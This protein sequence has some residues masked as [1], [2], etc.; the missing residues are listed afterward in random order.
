[1]RNNSN[2]DFI[3]MTDFFSIL[4]SYKKTIIISVIS[5]ALF[6]VLYSLSLPN[7]YTSTVSLEVKLGQDSNKS[8]GGF[9]G[10]S[11]LVGM[12][13]GNNK[14]AMLQ[15]M[16]MSKSFAKKLIQYEGIAESIMATKS[17]NISSGE[18]VYDEDIYDIAQK[19]W[20]RDISHPFKVIPS[21]LEIHNEYSSFL[22]VSIDESSGLMV[23]SFEHIS[24]FFSQY[25]IDIIVKEANLFMK[26][27]DYEESNKALKF[28]NQ[29]ILESSQLEVK[30]ALGSLAETQLKKQM[31]SDISDEYAL[32]TINASFVP[33]LKSS[34][35]R[36]FICILGT[37]IGLIIS[38]V[39]A[40]SHFFLQKNEN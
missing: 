12:N 23:I 26:N 16:I 38:V 11:S 21:Y 1:M 27:R 31:I 20:V 29:Q 17:F 22:S 7:K 14:S 36:A 8:S 19:K 6:S 5:F 10:L 9:G 37:F 30:K 24:P 13:T 35:N 40:M 18:L 25:F 28:L 3:S 15:S 33:E 32:S 34:P 4:V 2:D 39:I